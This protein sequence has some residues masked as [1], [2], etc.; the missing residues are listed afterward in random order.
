MMAVAVV[1]VEGSWPCVV[2]RV[3]A[4][5]VMAARESAGPVVG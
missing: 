2:W 4:A 1:F 5:M 3:A